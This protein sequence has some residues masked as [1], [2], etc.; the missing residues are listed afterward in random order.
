MNY[1]KEQLIDAI[2]DEWD[3]LCHECPEDGDATPEEKRVELE[4]MTLEELIEE[5]DTDNEY[6]TLDQYMENHG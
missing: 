1:T 6:Y 4:A 3:H 2:V 5:T